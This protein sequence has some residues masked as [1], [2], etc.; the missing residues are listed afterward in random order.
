M[1]ETKRGAGGSGHPEPGSGHDD[2]K[3]ETVAKGPDIEAVDGV[4]G[5]H[6]E[7]E[8]RGGAVGETTEAGKAA[9]VA[10]EVGS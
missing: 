10:D 7:V 9:E 4:P 8:T 5:A 2:S 3:T 1:S 6:G